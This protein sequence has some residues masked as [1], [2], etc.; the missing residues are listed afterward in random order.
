MLFSRA[1]EQLSF[2]DHKSVTEHL[3]HM[4]R[5]DVEA[6]D[7][8]TNAMQCKSNLKSKCDKKFQPNDFSSSDSKSNT[9][10]TII[11]ND[12]VSTSVI[13]PNSSCEF[14]ILVI[15][16]HAKYEIKKE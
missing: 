7:K 9:S 11:F 6:Q 2:T 14:R 4:D 1:G 8:R 10:T 5:D 15:N 12:N 16:L 13:I 3:I